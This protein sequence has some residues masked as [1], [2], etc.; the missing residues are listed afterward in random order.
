MG[1]GG[2]VAAPLLGA[3][4]LLEGWLWRLMAEAE[5]CIIPFLDP[6]CAWYPASL[7]LFLLVSPS[8]QRVLGSFH[9]GHAFIQ[10]APCERQRS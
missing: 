5:S 8:E 4:A 3:G 10:Q 1:G 6:G 2:Y 9:E 7:F